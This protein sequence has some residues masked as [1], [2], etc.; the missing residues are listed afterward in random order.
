MQI[1]HNLNHTA[2]LYKFVLGPHPIIQFFIDK[3]NISDIIDSYIKQDKRS[4]LFNEKIISL[5]IHN[6]LTASSPMYEIADWAS[7]INEPSLGLNPGE[8]SLVNDDRVGKVIEHFYNSRHKDVFFHLAL[9]AI[10]LFNIDCSQI[11]QDTTTITF[12]GKYDGWNKLPLLTH[13]HNKDHR[14]DLKQLVLG[15]SVS[16]DGFVPLTHQIYDG[17]QTDDRLHPNSH[18]RLR[19]LL[20]HSN[21]IYV[22]D[23]KLA[24]EDNLR[25]IEVHGGLFV[26]VM[27]R[28]WKEEK[29]FKNK[30]LKNKVSWMHLLSRRNNRKP[31]SKKDHYYLAKG[32]YHTTRGYRLLWIRSTQKAQQD[33]DTRERR[34]EK[35]FRELRIIQSKINSYYLKTQ[36]SIKEKV[37]AFIKKNNC[38]QFVEYK[39]H[40]YV[41]KTKH[42]KQVG[43]PKKKTKGKIV[44][45]NNFSISFNRNEKQ[46]EIITL[47]DGIFPI[48]TNLKNHKPKKVL[49]IYKQQ[50]FLEKRHT[51]LKTYQ[52][53][54]PVYLK[55]PERI[56]GYLHIHI[57]SLMVATLIERQL[58]IGMKKENLQSLPIYPENR[59]CKY[60][61]MFDIARLFKQIEKYEIVQNGKV[62]SFPAKL[63]KIQKKTLELIGVPLSLYD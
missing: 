11:H 6:I 25:K 37:D 34:I 33:M 59:P 16:S 20:G 50:P 10:K 27:P 22:A 63:D 12:K 45:N 15:M 23:C 42:H 21:F 36:Q 17:N 5:L 56:I 47:L 9:R 31:D 51:Q 7:P 38:Q 32:Q 30:V 41:N 55:K 62:Q 54:T 53:I 61:T 39:I 58:K 2:S 3:L 14:P 43:R 35:T 28:T 49:E 46:I 26:S 8:G 57:I 40:T 60:P 18:A 13:G 4:Q 29:V 44:F 52:E 24:T 1:Q 19:T 48:I